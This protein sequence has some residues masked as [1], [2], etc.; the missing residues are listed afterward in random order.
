MFRRRPGAKVGSAERSYWKSLLAPL[1]M[2]VAVFAAQEI[3]GLFPRLV[4][5]FYSRAVFPTVAGALSFSRFVSFSLGEALLV[6]LLVA[7]AEREAY[8][9]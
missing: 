5:R 9:S 2:I 3:V 7:F 4:E 8:K 6:L 1:G